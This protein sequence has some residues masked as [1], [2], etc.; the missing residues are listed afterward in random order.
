MDWDSFVK[1]A[2]SLLAVIVVLIFGSGASA[3][4][5][6]NPDSIKPV[7]NIPVTLDSGWKYSIGDNPDW[8]TADFDDSGWELINKTDFIGSEIPES[9]LSERAWFRLDLEVDSTLF[10]TT[11]AFDI[12]FVGSAE[13][14]LNGELVHSWGKIGKTEED[15]KQL[16][17]FPVNPQIFNLGYEKEQV[18]ALR[19]VD[20]YIEE[21]Q[22]EYGGCG[23]LMR[24]SDLESFQKYVFS[25]LKANMGIHHITFGVSLA[26]AILHLLLFTFF[27]KEKSN[28]FYSLLVISLM[29]IMYG[30]NPFNM[31]ATID[32]FLARFLIFKLGLI[33]TGVFSGIFVFSIFYK[34]LPKLTFYIFGS[35]IVMIFIAKFIPIKII[36]SYIMVI[37]I[38]NTVELFKAWRFKKPGAIVIID[39]IFV[40]MF[41]F[42]YQ[43]L[44][45]MQI[46]PRFISFLPHQQEYLLG[47]LIMVLT[48][49]VYLAWRVGQ[50]NRNLQNKL[51]QVKDLSEKTIRMKTLEMENAQ[52]DLELAESRKRELL[53]DELED[54]NTEL[55]LMNR[56]L[57]ETQSQ[58]VQS[59]K[60]AS[61]GLL[62]AGVAHEINTPVGA[63]YSTQGTLKKAGE[64]LHEILK[65][66]LGDRYENHKKL[67]N[68]VKAIETVSGVIKTGGER[69]AAIVKRM[70]SFA[71]LDEA[72]LKKSDI[73]E[74]L[75][76][77]L[78]MMSHAIR[79][80]IEIVKEYGDI[81][82]FECYPGQL[83]Q[84]F[85]NLLM[86]AVQAIE[87]PGIITIKTSIENENAIISIS[88]TGSGIAEDKLDKIF[89]PGYTTK[90]VGVGTGLG[91]SICYNIIKAHNGKIDVESTVGSGTE[92]KVIVPYKR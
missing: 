45:D 25:Y 27:P 77:T 66:E 53:M 79:P 1:S 36:Y 46:I 80:E 59:E 71:R 19:L 15:S 65:E 42:M 64:N 40:S 38:I 61:L 48:M 10:G 5:L 32:Q 82:L 18:I 28:L 49:S 13:L 26:I 20:Y 85:L 58:L 23:F 81:Q 74:G 73:H 57:R 55:G 7:N 22:I 83:N 92:F 68:T 72:E 69:V 30:T 41:F 47:I 8:A 67:Q 6:L 70:K 24:I 89:D 84:V 9:G 52:K 11:L 35:G 62:T 29:M 88:D 54:A 21:F 17:V 2:K 56:E 76:D 50:T 16:F 12:R 37:Y 86:N 14:Y 33:C 75:E 4:F 34:K 63:I 44:A 39:G 91:L 78:T 60:M 43:M 51:I 87:G 90:G 31:Y 3:Q